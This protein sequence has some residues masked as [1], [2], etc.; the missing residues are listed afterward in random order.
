MLVKGATGVQCLSTQDYHCIYIYIFHCCPLSL[1]SPCGYCLLFVASATLNEIHLILFYLIMFIMCVILLYLQ[2]SRHIDSHNLWPY[3]MRDQLS[4]LD[5]IFIHVSMYLHVIIY[6]LSWIM[7]CH[8]S[9]IG[10]DNFLVVVNNGDVI[11][12]IHFPRCWPFVW[13]IHRSPMHSPHKG[14]WRRALIFYLICVW[15]NGWVNNHEAGDLRRQRDQYD[16]TVM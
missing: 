10:N 14:Q 8:N 11:K 9:T 1:N 3:A 12:W 5:H 13:G 7:N 16:V 6:I 15:I 2:T 4:N